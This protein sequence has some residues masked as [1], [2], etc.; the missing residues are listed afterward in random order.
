MNANRKR[1]AADAAVSAPDRDT[2]PEH[3]RKRESG[4]RDAERK[5][6]GYRYMIVVNWR[7]LS[8]YDIIE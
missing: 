2:D 1:R 3:E 5:W 7:K 8:I 4:E 6:I